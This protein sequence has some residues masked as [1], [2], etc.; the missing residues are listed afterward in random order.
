MQTQHL[1]D[2]E[3]Q[4]CDSDELQWL[5]TTPLPFQTDCATTHKLIGLPLS[6]AAHGA[7]LT[8]SFD[9]VQT[10]PSKHAASP[11]PE[12]L[13][14][15]H[16]CPDHPF[17]LATTH[18]RALF[19]HASVLNSAQGT[20]PVSNATPLHTSSNLPPFFISPWNADSTLCHPP[21]LITSNLDRAPHISY[22]QQ[23]IDPGG[24][25]FKPPRR[26]K[27]SPSIELGIRFRDPQREPSSADCPLVECNCHM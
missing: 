25:N 20:R 9:F 13:P 2:R 10:S 16:A 8:H 18:S 12:S 24:S 27:G 26:C 1:T 7:E 15:V 23:H 4:A 17:N 19:C 11:Q 5:M 22:H 21:Q 14:S 3:P 6:L